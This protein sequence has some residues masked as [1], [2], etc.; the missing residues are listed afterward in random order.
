MNFAANYYKQGPATPSNEEYIIAEIQASEK[1]G[2]T[3]KWYIGDNHV[4][5]YPALT[6]DNWKGAVRYGSGTSMEKNREYS[7]FENANYLTREVNQAYLEV[8]DHAGVTVPRRDTVDKRVIEDVRTGSATFGNGIIDSVEQVGGWPELLTYDVPL[9]TDMDG[10]PDE[11]ERDYGLDALTDD[12]AGDLDEDGLSNLGEYNAD[13]YPN[14]TDSEDDGMPDGWEV[15]YGLEPLVNDAGED[16]DSDRFSNLE[17]Y[18]KGTLPNDARSGL[19]SATHH[20]LRRDGLRSCLR[21]HAV[22]DRPMHRLKIRYAVPSATLRCPRQSYGGGRRD[23]ART[24]RASGKA[25][26]GLRGQ[27]PRRCPRS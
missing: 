20:P 25:G 24:R 9:D 7:P 12:T 11:W 16:L 23:Q 27:H 19:P 3:S 10:M 6:E 1:Y 5:G 8:L 21:I 14:D 13:T 22:Q 15:Q 4:N 18:T 17:E 2:Y 26:S